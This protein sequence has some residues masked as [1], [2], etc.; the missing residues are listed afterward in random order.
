MARRRLLS[1][2]AWHAVMALPS[3][4]RDL[5]RHCTLSA[6]D[7]DRLRGMRMA[8]NR[9]GHALLLCA[10]RHPG[11][12]L[13]PGERPPA[14]MV[15][16]VARQL[17]V[18]AEMLTRWSNRAQT[19]REQIGDI[20]NTHGFMMFG[21]D[22]AEAMTR[23]LAPAAQIERRPQRLIEILLA[24]LRRGRI[25]LPQPRVIELVVHRARAAAARVTW[26]ALAGDLAVA[27]IEALETLLGAAPGQEGLSRLAWLRQFPTAPGARGVHALLERLAVV[28]ALGVDRQRQNAVP[29]AA[30]D[31]IAMDGM[32]MT[33]QHLRGLSPP[34]QRATLVA[35]TLRLE[36]DLT[37]AVLVMFDRLMGRIAR[38]AERASAEG[39]AMA[40]RGA[41]NHL[42]TLVRAGRAGP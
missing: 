1:D 33:A 9:L 20:M 19:R 3:E 39:A 41:Q 30:F 22:E 26:R 17:G 11:R 37:D 34:R 38:K 6:E 18:D 12:A 4:E 23:W 10:V 40:R 32:S 42:R 16:W 14:A 5:V 36:T 27:Q 29:A 24:E 2:E 15:A 8:H 28:R 21:R 13:A 35:A 7:L 25:L 31:A